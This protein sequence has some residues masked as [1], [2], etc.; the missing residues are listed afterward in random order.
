M[1]DLTVASTSPVSSYNEWDPL[2]EVI[3]GI[4][5]GAHFPPYDAVTGAPLSAEQRLIFQQR[6]GRPFPADAAAA[7]DE[8]DQLVDIL[9][10][11]GVRVRRPEAR[12]HSRSFGSPDWASTGL[13]DAMPRDLLLVVGDQI[14]EA[15]MAWRSRYF[16]SSAYRSLMKEY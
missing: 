9:E 16:A 5:D 14:I 10:G 12:D 3:V 4:V 15:P 13:Y 8:L 7:R 1:S 6:A 11:E 2:E